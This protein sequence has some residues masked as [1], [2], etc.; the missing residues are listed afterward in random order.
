MGRNKDLK[1]SLFVTFVFFL[2]EVIGGFFAKSLALLSDAAHMFTHIFA[3]GIAFIALYFAEKPPNERATFGFH[4]G[5]V[6]SALLNALI[7]FGATFLII[8]EAIKR[9]LFPVKVYTL[10]MIF[11]AILGLFANLFVV[12]KLM[13]HKDLNIRG[14]FL[15]VLGDTFSS[16]AIILG[17]LFMHFTKKFFID[18]I[19]SIF[20][21]IVIGISAFKIVR[22]AL[23]ILFEASPRHI[24]LDDVI[25]EMKSVEKVKDVHS[26]NLW[27]L[28]SNIIFLNAHVLVDEEKLSNTEKIIKELNRKLSRFGITHST[29][30]FENRLCNE[31]SKFKNTRHP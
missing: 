30:Q 5:E 27:S 14:A 29:F 3:L 28:C 13:G 10:E 6:F 11:V 8:Y 26:I 20:I 2:V 24:N 19:L 12:I 21:A 9:M 4:R 23:Y 7:L 18:P 22:D 25:N 17:A 15:H 31:C 1:I 16:I